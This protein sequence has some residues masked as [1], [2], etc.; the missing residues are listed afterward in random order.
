M[1]CLHA[2][3]YRQEAQPR[4]ETRCKDCGHT[5]AVVEPGRDL[6]TAIDVAATEARARVPFCIERKNEEQASYNLGRAEA[7]RW[8]ASLVR[9]ESK[10]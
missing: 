5:L 4:T 8:A 6:A 3:T 10:P 7:L 1:T 2:E 9:G